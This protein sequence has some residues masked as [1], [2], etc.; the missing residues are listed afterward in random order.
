MDRDNDNR[1]TDSPA[2][3]PPPWMQD[4]IVATGNDGND[5]ARTAAETSTINPE[6]GENASAVINV[7]DDL[8]AYI[9]ILIRDGLDQPIPGLPVKID[10]PGASAI[11][12]T[13]TEHGAVVV[14]KGDGENVA[15]LHVRDE[16]G[17]YQQVC[18]IDPAKCT[19]GT[20]IVRSPKVAEKVHLRP[21]HQKRPASSAPTPAPAAP[22][23]K[24]ADEARPKAEH[25]NHAWLQVARDWLTKIM[26]PHDP[27]PSAPPRGAPR[28]VQIQA[29]NK[30]GN[31]ISIVTGPE[32]PNND[33]LCLGRNNI[34]RRIILDASKRYKLSPQSIAALI[35]AEAGK[36]EDTIPLSN[37]D[38]TPKLVK[39][40]KH[41]GKQAV[42]KI[43]EHWNPQ[44][45]NPTG[46]AGLTQFIVSTWLGQAMTRGCYIN[47][48]CVA[49]GWIREAMNTN[50]RKA[51]VF[52]LADGGTTDKPLSHKGDRHVRACLDQRFDAEWSIMA[53][54]EYGVAN[55]KRLKDLGFRLKDLNDAEKAK[56]MY[57]MHHEGEPAGPLVIRNKLNELPKGKF[58]SVEARIR[59]TLIAQVGEADAK[60]RIQK[61][62]GDVAKAYRNWLTD[63]IDDKINFVKFCCNPNKLSAP[64]KTLEILKK[65][66]GE[67]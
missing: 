53:A 55:L 36:V 11:E 12:A 31:P 58:V 35:D 24:P 42:R 63:Y 45:A 48:Q 41:K 49:K 20:V 51:C 5:T 47:E 19:T 64:P 18:E 67:N 65:I 39:N 29:A 43:G 50:G 30:S 10:M 57:L 6:G 2:G 15:A 8:D 56:M 4:A 61:A 1:S 33:N 59:A 22:S 28:K 38:G 16:T 40:G 27:L 32:C 9:A 13:T 25:E 60:N 26:H 66:G 34:Y 23:S 14:P 46:A 54:A 7:D 37:P 3:M 52:V 21:H 62:N 17:Q 44:S